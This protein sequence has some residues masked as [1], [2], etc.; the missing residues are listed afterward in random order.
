METVRAKICAESKTVKLVFDIEKYSSLPSEQGDG[1]KS[2][3]MEGAGYKWQLEV[4]PGGDEAD[5][6]DIPGL[7]QFR[8]DGVAVFLHC[9]G[10]FPPS[11]TKFT[12]RLVNQK[13]KADEEHEFECYWMESALIMRCTTQASVEDWEHDECKFEE[14]A[15]G[16]G[17]MSLI[18]QKSMADNSQGWKLDDR[19]QIEA[20]VTVFSPHVQK[21]TKVQ[22][23]K[24]PDTLVTKDLLRILNSCMQ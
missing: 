18:D 15:A 11:K 9:V 4:C 3:V 12:L 1:T 23:S 16:Y 17:S 19:V 22:A 2:P 5:A 13:G 21:V 24:T 20:E 8:K 10:T 14:G 7:A 6:T